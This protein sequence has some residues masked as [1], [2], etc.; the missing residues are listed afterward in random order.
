MQ[1]R[2]ALLGKL[3]D[4]ASMRSRAALLGKLTDS[5]SL[6]VFVVAIAYGL[7][8]LARLAAFGNPSAFILAGSHFVNARQ[9]PQGLVI[10]HGAGYDGQFYYRL[11]LNPFDTHQTAYGIRLD[12][13]AYRQQRILYPLVVWLFSL[14]QAQ[15]VPVMMIVVNYLSLILLGFVAARSAQVLG[16][17]ALWGL[18]LPFYPGFVLSV[19][20]D[21]AEPLAA[22]LLVTGLYLAHRRRFVAATLALTLA[23]LTRET[24]I[25]VVCAALLVWGGN[26]LRQRLRAAHVARTAHADTADASDAMDAPATVWYDP[27]H[28]PWYFSVV[29]LLVFVCWQGLLFVVWGQ[30]AFASGAGNLEA[31]LGG[32]AHLLGQV[33]K[34]ESPKQEATY[35][36]LWY[37]LIYGFFVGVSW[38]ISQ[39]PLYQRLAWLG[40][41]VLDLCLSTLVWVDDW[42]FLRGLSEFYL[43]GALILLGGRTRYAAPAIGFTAML[44]LFLAYTRTHVI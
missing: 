39:T 9:A 20:R 30:T 37:L 22:L 4:S 43:L 28:A 13:P 6:C 10:H 26:Q 38:R 32:I 41:V 27:L 31:P 1:A 14:G 34:L 15:L 24:A 23:L 35:W 21:L 7:F 44:W 29:P 5:A 25:L 33:A 40:F 3:T 18:A 8:I 2:I 16:R 12:R 42:A 11:A 36:E 19:A 17:H